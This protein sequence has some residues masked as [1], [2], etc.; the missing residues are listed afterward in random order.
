MPPFY[1][2]RIQSDRPNRIIAS[3]SCRLLFAPGSNFPGSAFTE[4]T[5]AGYLFYFY[6]ENLFLWARSEIDGSALEFCV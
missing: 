4:L 3:P 1:V 6:I 5:S 2:N